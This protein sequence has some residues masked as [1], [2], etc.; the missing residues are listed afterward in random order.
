VIVSVDG[1]TVDSA[2]T[3][4]TLLSAHHPGDR[5]QI[6]WIDQSGAQQTST[7]QL[8]TGPAA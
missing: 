5:V 4:S 8:A 3:L 1:R 2:T 6:G 7:V